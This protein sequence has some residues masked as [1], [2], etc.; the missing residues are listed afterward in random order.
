LLSHGVSLRFGLKVAWFD[1]WNPLLDEALVSLPNDE[2]C[3]PELYRLLMQTPGCKM[4]I[5]LVTEAGEPVAII[6]LTQV[7]LHWKLATEWIVPGFLFPAR[8]GSEWVGL[9]ALGL[10]LPVGWWRMEAP[11]PLVPWLRDAQESPTYGSL[12]S[13]DFEAYWRQRSTMKDVRHARNRCR[14]FEFRVDAPGM[15]EWTVRNWASKWH[16]DPDINQRLRVS[17]YLERHDRMHTLSLHS[18]GEPSAGAILL[19]HRNDAVAYVN[20]RDPQYD[21][22]GLMTYLIDRSFQWARQ[23]G[24]NS[25]DIG[26]DH[27]YKRG[28]A[29]EHGRKWRFTVRPHYALLGTRASST[30]DGCFRLTKSLLSGLRGDAGRSTGRAR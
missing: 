22:F 7:G 10:T 16:A 4:G 13:D 25:M 9:A 6:G 1:A 24:Y 28:W 17:D 12:C 15:R 8:R 3:P 2:S 19:V 11:P 5:A 18:R 20:Y 30:L 26:G 29:P 21:S 23:M 14:D 27:D